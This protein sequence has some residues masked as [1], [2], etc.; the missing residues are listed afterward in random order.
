M[1]ATSS[2]IP[3]LD[4]RPTRELVM[5]F[6]EVVSSKVRNE[7]KMRPSPGRVGR[8]GSI[9]KGRWLKAKGAECRCVLRVHGLGPACCSPSI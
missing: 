5:G 4:E 9:A 8:G 7:L 2:Q 1:H 3:R 6:S